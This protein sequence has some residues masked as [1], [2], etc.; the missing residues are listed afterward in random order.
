M[1]QDLAQNPIQFKTEH[2]YFIL[3]RKTDAK[4]YSN[5]FCDFTRHFDLPPG[6]ACFA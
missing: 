2:Q 1:A 3:S 6:K 5:Y 4:L